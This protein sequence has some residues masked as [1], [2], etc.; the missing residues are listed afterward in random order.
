MGRK[1]DQFWNYAEEQDSRFKCKFCERV[2]PRGGIRIKAHLAGVSGCDIVAC[3][4]VS[5]DVQKEAQET[6]K[7]NKKLESASTSSGAEKRKIS[8]V[9]TSKIKDKIVK[10]V[11]I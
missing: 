4:D 1:R 7:S 8:L 3:V 5:Q 11:L 10:Q 2:F 6:Q 9:S